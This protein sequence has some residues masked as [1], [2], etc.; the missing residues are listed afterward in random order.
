MP[1]LSENIFINVT[2]GTLHRPRSIV[3]TTKQEHSKIHRGSITRLDHSNAAL[4]TSHFM[5][6]Q[7]QVK[8]H[9]GNMCYQAHMFIS[10]V[11][12]SPDCNI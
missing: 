7:L 3:V 6:R 12:F 2:Y 11:I 10:V 5:G 4:K 1:L 8:L 9:C